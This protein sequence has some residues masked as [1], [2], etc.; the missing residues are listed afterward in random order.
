MASVLAMH[1]NIKNN[2]FYMPWNV[3]KSEMKSLLFSGYKLM[4]FLVSGKVFGRHVGGSNF[5]VKNLSSAYNFS[6]HMHD[7]KFCN[8]TFNHI[9]VLQMLTFTS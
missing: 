2:F 4:S 7:P 6:P 8:C 3:E 9:H 1:Y 5:I